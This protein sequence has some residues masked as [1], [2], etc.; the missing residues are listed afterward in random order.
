MKVTQD[1]IFTDDDSSGFDVRVNATALGC[2]TNDMPGQV[3]I[4][5]PSGEVVEFDLC[6]E[7]VG[8]CDR[9][10]YWSYWNEDWAAAINLQVFAG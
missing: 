4:E 7:V 8:S 1:Q 5:L 6:G 2:T 9:F 10:L 3:S